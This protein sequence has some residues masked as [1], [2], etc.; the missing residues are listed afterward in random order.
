MSTAQPPAIPPILE[1]ADKYEKPPVFLIVVNAALILTI[2]AILIFVIP[3]FAA[4]FADSGGK[5]P[6]LTLWLIDLSHFLKSTFLVFNPLLIITVAFGIFLSRD[7][8]SR[9]ILK[10]AALTQVLI[11]VLIIVGMFLLPVSQLG[12]VTGGH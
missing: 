4:M 2:D 12:A 3:V 6:L 11:L 8:P 5:P 10:W 1:A 9:G 7:H